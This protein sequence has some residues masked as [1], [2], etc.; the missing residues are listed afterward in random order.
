MIFA[1]MRFFFLSL[2]CHLLLILS[3]FFL[4]VPEKPKV[5]E[6]KIY[7]TPAPPKP[8]QKKTITKKNVKPAIKASPPKIISNP[9]LEINN[10]N[11]DNFEKINLLEDLDEEITPTNLELE[12]I[13]K[14]TSIEEVEIE[15][16]TP[17][18]TL[19][20]AVKNNTE[21]NSQLNYLEGIAVQNYKNLLSSIVRNNWSS[22]LQ[23]TNLKLVIKVQIQKNGELINY[24]VIKESGVVSFDLSAL[25]AIK[26]SQPF[27]P[28]P[29]IYKEEV[30]DFY[31]QFQG[32]SILIPQ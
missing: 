27:P 15:T 1:K 10:L 31:F 22:P 3:F 7:F 16:E 8:A 29:E 23:D 6:A 19:E 18:E 24:T 26:I 21:N 25:G 9:S 32:G 11:L 14:E 2:V 5:F 12:T 30:V 4:K 13:E 28:L 20:E 17:N